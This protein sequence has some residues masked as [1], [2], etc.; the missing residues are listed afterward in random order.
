[1]VEATLMGDL[2]GDPI[3]TIAAITQ[4][5][6]NAEFK[7][8]LFDANLLLISICPPGYGK[9]DPTPKD[10]SWTDQTADDMLAVLDQLHIPKCVLLI[11]YT[12]APMSYR[13]A[14]LPPPE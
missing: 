4:Y 13:I 6:F 12:N 8:M 1:M 2:T 3:V 5:T 7:Q 11:K 10:I 14:T 9:T